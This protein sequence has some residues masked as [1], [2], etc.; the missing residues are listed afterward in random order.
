M[1]DEKMKKVLKR[2]QCM[3]VRHLEDL[4]DEVEQDGGRIKDHMV[5]DG[6]KD[7]LKSLHIIDKLMGADKNVGGD[8]EPAEETGNETALTAKSLL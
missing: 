8:S 6:T 2:T 3:L 4:N 1:M 5:L 7:A